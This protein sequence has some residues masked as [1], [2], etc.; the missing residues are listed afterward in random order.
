MFHKAICTVL[1]AVTACFSATA[2]AQTAYPT[3][4][5]RIVVPYPAGGLLD[6][7]A[8]L[9]APKLQLAMGQPIVVYNHGGASGVIGATL[10][11][12]APADGYTLLF[13]GFGPN[14]VNASILASMSYDPA[15]DFAPVIEVFRTANVLVVGNQVGVNSVQELTDMARRPGVLVTVATAGKGSATHL[16]AE[17]YRL[18]VGVDLNVIP[19]RGDAP[20][21]RA[22]LGGEVQAYFA[23]ASTILPHVKTGRLRA[24][25]VTSKDRF[26]TLPDVPTLAQAGVPNYEAT[27]WYGLYAPAGTPQEVITRLNEQINA[28]LQQP[29]VRKALLGD[30]GV[31]I[32][33]G[34]P[35]VLKTQTDNE[36]ARWRKV[37]KSANLQME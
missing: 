30:G 9:L 18:A 12:K 8:R 28:I 35:D 5:I 21:I 37:V 34:S 17:L 19:Y 7:V 31:D 27:A 29:D 2:P 26:P 1:L 4:P 25:A 13:G 11:A 20:A 16:F 6:G 23:A 3:K 33:G 36:T 22:M 15:K 10:A 14:A 24:L 32:I